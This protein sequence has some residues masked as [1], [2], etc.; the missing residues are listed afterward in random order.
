M[1]KTYITLTEA[2]TKAIK[3]FIGMCRMNGLEGMAEPSFSFK[4]QRE[5]L[6]TVS[7]DIYFRANGIQEACWNMVVKVDT[8]KRIHDNQPAKSGALY[9]YLDSYKINQGSL[10]LIH[11]TSKFNEF[12]F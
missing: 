2:N 11:K 4:E 9:S 6:G 1:G 3:N 7:F 5:G 8:N 10:D 12:S